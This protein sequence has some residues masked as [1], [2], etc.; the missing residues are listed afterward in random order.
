MLFCI[1]QF[2]LRIGKTREK[3]SRHGGAR[4]IVSQKDRILKNL[5]REH[6]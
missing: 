6:A 1:L 4:C 5:A 3:D 2:N